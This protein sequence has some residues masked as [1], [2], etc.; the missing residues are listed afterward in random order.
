MF[1][2]T[3]LTAQLTVMDHALDQI[4]SLSTKLRKGANS[5]NVIHSLNTVSSALQ[6]TPPFVLTK[7]QLFDPRNLQLDP[8]ES[9]KLV[10][11][12]NSKGVLDGISKMGGILVGGEFID[13]VSP[14]N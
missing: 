1:V 12:L 2:A 14:S 4:N 13:Q 7:C 9:S 8:C 10:S 11:K 6:V 5:L 3:R